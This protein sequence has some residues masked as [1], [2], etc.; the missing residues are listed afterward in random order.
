MLEL[1]MGIMAY[2][3]ESNIGR[4]LESVINQRFTHGKLNEIFVVASGC[5]DRT[6]EIVHTF[7]EKD[8]RIILLSEAERKGKSSAINLFLS[9]ASGNVF[10]LESGD[11]VPAQG[12]LDKLTAPFLDP[13]VGMTGGR[14]VPV[15]PKNRF[16]GYCVHLQWNLHHEIAKETPKL[17][18]LVVFRDFVK[19]IP[20]DSAVDEASIEAIARHQGYEL[21]YVPDAVL[22]NK[23][24]ENVKDFLRQR[25]RIAA[26]H[27]HLKQ[28]ENYS[29]STGSPLKIFRVLLKNHKWRFK[30]TVWTVGAIALEVVGRL[31][32]FYDLHI[33]KK[34]PFIWDIASST[35]KLDS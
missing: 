8:K 15:N 16:I 22:H 31:L 28:T 11:T 19:Q 6:E 13:K 18:E 33:R 14:P 30:D 34:N 29:V 7:M 3:E 9:K 26:G 23:G 1:S 5:T 4:L 35:K 12:T 20:A 21:H 25:R 24:P 2:N 27:K 32:G 17:G 10:I